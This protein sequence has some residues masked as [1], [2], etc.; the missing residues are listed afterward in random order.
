MA[1][2]IFRHW[3]FTVKRQ[4]EGLAVQGHLDG[5]AVSIGELNARIHHRLDALV[6]QSWRGRVVVVC[7][8]NAA[9]W[10]EAFLCCQAKGAIVLPVDMDQPE[11]V[12]RE[13]CERFRPVAL[14][15]ESGIESLPH[16][17]RY[18]E[19]CLIK[20]TSGS[21]GEAR[22]LV[23]SDEQ[24]LADGRQVV[25]SMG[26]RSS[27]INL[28]T[29]PLGH[30][31]GLGNLV[32]PLIQQGTGMVT[33]SD[34]YPHSIA[35]A[36]ERGG[37]SVYPT[38]PAVLRI[39]LNA[40]VDADKMKSLRLMVSAGSALEPGLARAFLEKYGKRIHNFYGS[41]E[42]GAIA[43]DASGDDT[44]SGRSI[45]KPVKGLGIELGAG[46]KLRVS[47]PA[48]YTRYNRLRSG[49]C[50]AC[51]L[52]DVVE[53]L[54]DGALVLK[55]RRSRMRKL[56]G[57]RLN[58]A[59]VERKLC[60]IDGVEAAYVSDFEDR[61]GRT[62]LGAA[63]V[64][65]AGLEVVKSQLRKR[66]AAWKLPHHWVV[67]DRLPVNRRGKTDRRKLRLLIEQENPG[68]AKG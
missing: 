34:S 41:S 28:A 7:L 5:D 48:V 4:S 63:L 47:G 25:T 54:E 61:E 58:L 57:K 44:L 22:P 17:R 46:G 10:M 49:E 53:V 50:G 21:T 56:G 45:G 60:D 37:V 55:G 67:L 6:D 26:I 29:I 39:L 8:P 24:M 1:D 19:A 3:Q 9:I 33:L 32:M 2:L 23:F 16:A 18:Q 40:E 42:T 14:W 65:Q 31:Y 30:S 64:G 59:E 36:V 15:S 27:D 11:A 38:V 51:V 43:Y 20:M 68:S 35:E 62:R 12:V 52:P 13:L 66:L